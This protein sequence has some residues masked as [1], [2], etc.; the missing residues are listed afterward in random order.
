MWKSEL[1]LSNKYCAIDYK[2]CPASKFEKASMAR[3]VDKY[4]YDTH[5]VCKVRAYDLNQRD[6]KTINNWCFENFL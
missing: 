6:Y 5:E 3:I 1:Q 2:Y 4:L